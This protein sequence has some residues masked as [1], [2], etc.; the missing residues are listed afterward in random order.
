MWHSKGGRG[1]GFSSVS[2]SGLTIDPQTSEVTS[3]T[4][5]MIGFADDTYVDVWVDDTQN[6]ED[7]G[8]YGDAGSSAYSHNRIGDKSR[9]KFMEKSPADYSDAMI[10]TQAEIDAG[11]CVGDAT[12]GVSDA[13]AAIYWSAYSNLKAIVPERIL[14][15]PTG[16]RGDLEFGAVWT[17]GVWKAEIGRKL[18]TGNDDD[19]QFTNLANEYL[20][21]VA[22]FDNSRHGYEHRTSDNL[23][24]KFI[25]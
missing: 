25:E 14:S 24:M 22:Q 16:S 11:E 15:T 20:F 23:Y 1:A 6:G 5:S 8:R 17:D 4:L 21:N 10:L 19:I 18:N 3:G 9:P 7:G 12:T 13:D 2:G